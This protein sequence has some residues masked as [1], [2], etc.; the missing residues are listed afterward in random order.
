MR[1]LVRIAGLV[2][3][4]IALLTFD[5]HESP[6]EAKFLKNGVRAG[7][8][9]KMTIRRR[10]SSG[11]RKRIFH[12]TERRP[13]VR[14]PTKPKTGRREAHAWFWKIHSTAASAAAASRF[15]AALAT[16]RDRRASGKTPTTVTAL[17]RIA[18]EYRTEIADAARKHRVSEALILAVIAIESRGKA[19]ALSP[20]GAQGLMQLI[21]ATAARFG[22]QEPFNP[23]QNIAGGAAYLSW[24]LKTFAGDPLLALA[25]Y[26][27]GEGAVRQH[28]GV[29][30]F[31][32]TRDYIVLVMDA[33][34]AAQTLCAEP[35]TTPRQRCTP[36]LA[37]G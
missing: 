21:P 25:G 8:R 3:G 35:L 12:H 26:N 29:P 1:H 15:T 5:G 7:D 2:V 30:P 20:K 27:A 16:M 6:V 24:L 11:A 14:S 22:V 17:G 23:A 32:E 31:A 18:T 33:L 37:D 10:P 13:A 19:K 34:A 36:R 4:G 9:T 28:K